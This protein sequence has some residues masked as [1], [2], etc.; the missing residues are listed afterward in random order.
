MHIWGDF[1]HGKSV[2]SIQVDV[3]DNVD[4]KT[5][6]HGLCYYNSHIPNMFGYY[7]SGWRTLLILDPRSQRAGSYK[8]GAVIVNV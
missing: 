6:I 4:L 2:L 3:K 8:I 1:N 5:N 7:L